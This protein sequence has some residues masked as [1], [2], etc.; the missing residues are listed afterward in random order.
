MQ[1]IFKFESDGIR[2]DKAIAD[3]LADYSR[4]EIARWIKE[5][6]VTVDGK[7]VKVS[8]LSEAGKTVEID[9]PNEVEYFPKAEELPLDIIY[10]D[11][12]IIVI[13]KAKGMV[14]HPGVGNRSGT[15]VNAL[16]H[17][18]QGKLSDTN[19]SDRLGIVHRL[20]KNTS[21]LI[22]TAKNSMAH[23][24]L[25]EQFKQREVSKIYQA[26]VHGSFIETSGKI[27]APIARDKNNRQKMA[28]DSDG[29]EAVSYFRVLA[30]LEKATYLEVKLITG[31]T[32][33]I[34]VHMAYINHPLLGDNI[35]GIRKNKYKEDGQYLHASKLEFTHPRTK[36]WLS[37]EVEPPQDFAELL[38][39]LS[40]LEENKL[41]WSEEWNLGAIDDQEIK[42]SL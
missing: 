7:Y 22:V 36:E 31:R 40:Y 10:E 9:I 30:P 34:R 16:I 23:I 6:R 41:E 27:V 35:Y 2:V 25:Q 29:R 12:D 3:V 11:E 42:T 15:L 20:D 24:D 38:D 8:A 37:F 13:N 26:I 5:K 33:Q 14:V 19:G 21:G 39:D 4:S 1:K 32:H 17:H 18:T 28:V